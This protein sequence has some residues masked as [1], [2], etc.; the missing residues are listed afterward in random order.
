MQTI[1]LQFFLCA[2]AFSF[3]NAIP[4][5]KLP[6]FNHSTWIFILSLACSEVCESIGYWDFGA[7]FIDK[8]PQRWFFLRKA[9]NWIFFGKK[10]GSLS[11]AI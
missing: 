2:F 9:C 7:A 8:V 10:E 3:H 4:F 5:C 1:S 6:D 11:F